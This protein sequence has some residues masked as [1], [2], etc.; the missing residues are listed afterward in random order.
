MIIDLDLIL[1]WA[2][3]VG[4]FV[5]ALSGGIVAVRNKMD[6]FGAV[7]L[8]IIT[9][10]GGGTIRDIILNQPVFWLYDAVIIWCAIA[11]GL[12]AF[13]LHSFVDAFKPIRWADALGL[14]I[15]AIAGAAKTAS[16]G[17][18]PLFVVIMGIL[19]GTGG[20]VLRDVVANRDP[21]LLKEEIY[22]TAAMVG[23][24]LYAALHFSGV[25]EGWAFAAGGLVAFVLR[26]AA[27]VFGWHLPKSQ[28]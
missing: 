13:F 28:L 15:F 27:L 5:F 4:A 18:D 24:G 9:A 20:G 10:V 7:V 17:H 19:T 11:G 23:A 14:A 16:L 6:I 12:M 3:P 25:P 8:A 2:N 21:L 22:A 1:S 26:G